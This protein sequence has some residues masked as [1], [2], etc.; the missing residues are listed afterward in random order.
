MLKI[1]KLPKLRNNG[2]IIRMTAVLNGNS[3]LVTA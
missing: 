1:V 2:K 3:V